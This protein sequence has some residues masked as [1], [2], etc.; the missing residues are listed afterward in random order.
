MLEH[1]EKS[2]TRKN[3][4]TTWGNKPESTERRKIKKIPTKSKTIHTKQDI[5]NNEREFY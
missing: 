2:N 1:K 3:N 4:D 5:P